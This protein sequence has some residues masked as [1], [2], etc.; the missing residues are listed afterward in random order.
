M[1]LLITGIVQGVGYRHGLRRQALRLGLTGWVRNRQDGRVEAMVQ[2]APE[3]V[4][5]LVAW[6]NS[7]PPA[8]RVDGV[9][10]EDAGSEIAFDG[11]EQRPTT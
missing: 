5:A 3:A 10:A 9:T 6:A 1:H 8:A 11:F 4:A 2:G 7:G